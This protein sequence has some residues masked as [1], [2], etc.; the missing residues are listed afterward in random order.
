MKLR[1][2]TAS[3][4]TYLID[5]E[6][7]TWKRFN[8]NVGHE[9]I[10]GLPVGTASGPLLAFPT[11]MVGQGMILDDFDHRIFTTPVVLVEDVT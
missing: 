3:G 8:V 2:H 4:S 1:V 11:V 9:D 6:A 10:L 5:G 7:L